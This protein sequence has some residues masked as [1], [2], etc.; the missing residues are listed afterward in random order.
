MGSLGFV[1]SIQAQLLCEA[2]NERFLQVDFAD[3]DQEPERQGYLLFYRCLA[4]ATGYMWVGMIRSVLLIG[5]SRP[6]HQGG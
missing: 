6:L 5:Q 4:L 1:P 3:F 2:L